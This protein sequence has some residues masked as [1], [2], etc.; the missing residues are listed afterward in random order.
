MMSESSKSS[1]KSSGSK[2]S[3]GSSTSGSSTVRGLTKAQTRNLLKSIANN[4][5]NIY[6]KI[7]DI[8]DRYVYDKSNVD[9]DAVKVAFQKE[10]LSDL[11]DK[12]LEDHPY[13]DKSVFG[14]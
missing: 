3:S 7:D 13:V 8:L 9:S 12:Y 14:L 11:I 2:R 5:E 10:G 4:Q 6:K 1:K